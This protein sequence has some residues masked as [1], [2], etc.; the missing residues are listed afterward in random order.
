M[1]NNVKFVLSLIVSVFLLNFYKLD[2]GID[3]FFNYGLGAIIPIG[4]LFFFG[5]AFYYYLTGHEFVFKSKGVKGLT[6]FS[7][8]FF[9]V[10]SLI[11]T[12][13]GCHILGLV[14]VPGVFIIQCFF[15]Y[16]FLLQFVSR[17][18]RERN[19]GAGQC[20]FCGENSTY[21]NSTKTLMCNSC[22]AFHDEVI[23]GDIYG[24]LFVLSLVGPSVL[25]PLYYESLG[26]GHGADG[27]VMWYVSLMG[28]ML[29]VYLFGSFAGN[30]NVWKKKI[31]LF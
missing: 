8:L 5:L 1:S 15:V 31:N 11:V 26:S 10:K 22:G 2:R 20:G 24:F 28:G 27:L 18:I 6:A 19:K 16:F 17:R 29:L 12:W 25:V 9:L 13:I 30:V 21:D 7:Y 14:L 23:R 3:S 4:G